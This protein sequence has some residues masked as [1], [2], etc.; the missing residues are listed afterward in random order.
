MNREVWWKSAVF[1]Q[2]YPRSFKDSNG[3][4]VGD[5]KGLESKLPYLRTLGIDALWISPFYR[6][7]M[8][9]FG[10]D[11]ADYCAVDPLF[12]DM[13][14]FD[15]LLQEA[16][17][18][19]IRIIIDMVLNH[20]SDQHPWFVD[21]RSSVSSAKHD[22]Y[23][24]KPIQKGPFGLLKKP[25]N[26]VA[27]FELKS[28]W[29]PNAE[30]GEYY[31]G[32]F[33]RHQPE[34]DW[35]NP[36]LKNAMYDVLRF[37]LDKGVDGFRLDVVNWFIKDSE[38]RSNPRNLVAHPDIFQK[39]IYDRN[40]AETHQICKEMRKLSDSYQGNRV[41]VGEIF[42]QDPGQAA[43]Y[44]GKD[45]DELHMAFNFDLAYRSWSARELRQSI[46]TWYASLPEGAWPNMTLSNHDQPRH[47]WRFRGKNAKETESRA[48]LAAALLLSLRGTPFIYYGEEIGMMQTKISKKELRDPLGIKT[49]P[50]KLGR[51]GERSPMQWTDG[52]RAGFSSAAPWLP[53]NPDHSFRNVA[54]YERDE[55]SLLSWYKGLIA[56]RKASSAL[57]R[58][59][60]EFFDEND[61][62]VI[63]FE[64]RSEG[65]R[66]LVA[67]NLSRKEQK[68][69]KKAHKR[70]YGGQSS[71]KSCLRVMAGTH[72]RVGTELKTLATLNSYEVLITIY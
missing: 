48:R 53:I 60:I 69:P 23:I 2:V 47:A 72:R 38:F 20:T 55:G 15:R 46:Q 64:R 43:S 49:W 42:C 18:L 17:K 54:A 59:E 66:Y 67:L 3:D 35:R 32:T 7:P 24:W 33:T 22:W 26:W 34:V 50:L 8:Q 37:W 11:I 4:G 1:Y 51:D 58:G 71:S 6:S 31:L 10:Y 57:K 40:Q 16:H 39:H 29:W 27:Q 63:C 45:L 56:L 12:G 62:H 19:D 28:A 65:E 13:Q 61:A 21:A 25:N 41:L 14:A 44:H 5:L 9:D 68:L 36:E 30:T 70:L 52:D